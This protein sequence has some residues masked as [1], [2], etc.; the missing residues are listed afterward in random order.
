MARV[1][2]LESGRSHV[3]APT[4]DLHLLL[5]VTRRRL[6]LVQSL[7]GAV[8][9]LVQTPAAPHRDPA[10]TQLGQR[11]VRGFDRPKQQRRVYHLGQ[12]A[13]FFQEA[14]RVDRFGVAMLAERD[15]VPARE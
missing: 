7:Q 6:S 2:N 1:R 15:V 11:K 8:V 13:G 10:K 5:S 4:P 12:Q 3:V 14:T 9:S